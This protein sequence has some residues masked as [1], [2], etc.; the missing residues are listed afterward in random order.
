MPEARINIFVLHY[1]VAHADSR[2]NP[3]VF[4]WREP[5]SFSDDTI[6]YAWASSWLAP[7]YA[8][9]CGVKKLRQRSNAT[10]YGKSNPIIKRASFSL[11]EFW[12]AIVLKFDSSFQN[13]AA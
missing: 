12:P 8:A 2:R 13:L 3:I 5:L 11:L 6:R 1:N 9:K 7:G 4:A 10:V